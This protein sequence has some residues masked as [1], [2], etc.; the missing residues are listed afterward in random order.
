MVVEHI[1]LQIAGAAS[2][3]EGVDNFA[4]AFA[5]GAGHGDELL[6]ELEDEPVVAGGV[7]A[8]EKPHMAGGP[9]EAVLDGVQGRG[10]FS[11][12]RARTRRMA[13]S[14]LGDGSGGGWL[15]FG[16][17]VAVI[18]AGAG[19]GAEKV[20]GGDWGIWGRRVAGFR[21]RLHFGS[22]NGHKSFPFDSVLDLG[23]PRDG[24][25]YWAAR[26]F[27]KNLV[28]DAPG[29][30][31]GDHPVWPSMRSRVKLARSAGAGKSL[32]GG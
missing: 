7:L 29:W 1:S 22:V 8:M 9:G 24:G 10:S 30:P 31:F 19:G 5:F 23:A 4:D 26:A 13:G 3:P 32:R 15:V 6:V 2:Q 14:G 12:R 21:T 20:G 11:C 16:V 28:R 25:A 17:Y 27:S 18:G